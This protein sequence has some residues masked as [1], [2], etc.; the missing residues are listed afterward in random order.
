MDFVHAEFRTPEDLASALVALADAGVSRDAVNV[1][2]R[3]PL[4]VP[5]PLLHTASRMS[6]GA[7]A[8]AIVVGG[9][10]TT[11][12]YSI[13][14]DYP[15]VTGGMPVVSGWATGVVTF[16]TTMAGAVLGIVLMLIR[17][18]RL[19]VFR[20]TAPVPDLPDQGAVLQVRCRADHSA[21][22]DLLS[23]TAAVSV[24][25]VSANGTAA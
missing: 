20:K 24:S 21:V 14:L 11:L 23:R 8:S 10:A 1:F 4:E 12:L 16:E 5:S 6:L 19:A 3:R 13:Q 15:L 18:G 25:E 2:S 9:G 17:E 7:V 22:A